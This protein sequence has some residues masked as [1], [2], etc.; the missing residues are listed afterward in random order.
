MSRIK[1]S[2][3][4]P[5]IFSCLLCKDMIGLPGQKPEEVEDTIRFVWEAGA[6]PILAEYSPIPQTALWQDAVEESR[7]DIARE[8]LFHNNSL[9]PFR[10]KFFSLETYSKLKQMTRQAG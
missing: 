5:S 9:V 7:F 3:E 6:K 8:P 4:C 1:H 2:P 10:S